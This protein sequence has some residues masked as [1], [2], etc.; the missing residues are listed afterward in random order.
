M[1]APLHFTEEETEVPFLMKQTYEVLFTYW[2]TVK[3]MRTVISLLD[4][5]AGLNF[6]H[7]SLI[8]TG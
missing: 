6:V 4:T 3:T 5:G 7:P 1:S 8:S 2:V